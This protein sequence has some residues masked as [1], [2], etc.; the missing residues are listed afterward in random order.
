MNNSSLQIFLGRNVV[1]LS[2]VRRHH[3]AQW[4]DIRGLF[5][6]TNYE[7]LNSEFGSQVLHF[8]APKGIGMGYPYKLYNLCVVWDIFRQEYRVFGAEQVTIKQ[9]WDVTTPEGIDNFKQYFYDNIINMSEDDK[10]KFMGLVNDIN[11]LSTP[12]ISQ[13]TKKGIIQ[14]ISDKAKTF[15]DRIKKYFK[16]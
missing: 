4:S 3:K 6:T 8:R 15:V 9:N 10:L 2:F 11:I 14:R 5:G 12:T 16:K 7:L 1:E 13:Q